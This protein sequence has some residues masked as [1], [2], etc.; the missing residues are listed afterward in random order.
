[1]IFDAATW[2]LLQAAGQGCRL[3]PAMGLDNAEDHI[4]TLALEAVS[5]L[6]HFIGLA[7]AGGKA[8]VHLEPATLLLVN[9]RQEMFRRGPR[10]VGGHSI[11]PQVAS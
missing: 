6:Q 8:Q 4:D 11:S 7:D 10:A 5:F 9:Q 3:G 2:H 1:M